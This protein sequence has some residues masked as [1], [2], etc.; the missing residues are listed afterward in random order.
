MANKPT[1]YPVGR[2]RKGEIRPNSPV[3]LSKAKWRN[4]WKESDPE[5]F[6]AYQRE[7]NAAHKARHPE[8]VKAQMKAAYERSKQWK[9]VE[10]K[11]Q[12]NDLCVIDFVNKLKK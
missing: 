4:E 12:L 8:R 7:A 11:A 1:G 9:L 6:A 5:G 2:P 10:E 3:T